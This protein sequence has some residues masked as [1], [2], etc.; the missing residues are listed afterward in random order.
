MEE[1]HFIL[2]FIN[3]SFLTMSESCVYFPKVVVTKSFY[4]SRSVFCFLPLEL[5]VLLC[6]PIPTL[7]PFHSTCKIFSSSVVSGCLMYLYNLYPLFESHHNYT[8]MT[9][10]QHQLS[11][12]IICLL[13]RHTIANQTPLSLHRSDTQKDY[14]LNTLRP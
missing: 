9:S 10:C 14:S 11:I 3:Y 1:I 7:C 8:V 4:S 6:H 5:P 13:T 12:P 2:L